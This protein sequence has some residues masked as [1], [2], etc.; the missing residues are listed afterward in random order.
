M[1]ICVDID[2]VDGSSKEIDGLSN[3]SIEDKDE[4]SN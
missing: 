4:V 1:E 3:Q 2:N